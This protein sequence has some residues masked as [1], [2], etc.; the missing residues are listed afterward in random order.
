MN[1]HSIK[2]YKNLHEK[3]DD[4]M[5]IIKCKCEKYICIHKKLEKINNDDFIV[6]NEN[7]YNLIT[8]YSYTIKQLKQI[9]QI[10][11]LKISGIRKELVNR[12]FIYLRL[13]FFIIKI[14]KIFR[15]F[16][17]RRY[18]FYHGPAFWDRSLCTN[19][20]DFFTMDEITT[21]PHSQFFSYK[22]LDGFIYGFDILSLYNLILKSS[23]KVQNPY[24]RNEIQITVF[25]HI[26]NIIRISKIYN[27]NIEINITDDQTSL[28]LQKIVELRSLELFQNIDYLGNYSNSNWFLSLNRIELLKFMRELNDIWNFRIQLTSE[29]KRSICPPHGDPFRNFRISCITSE[30][31]LFIVK[32]HILEV[33]EKFVNTGIDRDSKSLGCYYVLGALTLVNPNAA[34]SMPWLYQSFSY[35]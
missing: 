19:N 21:L 2:K 29:I 23:K 4:Y 22:D 3:I 9:A 14:Q 12:I 8:K 13:S 31:D 25:N 5:D 1:I 32:K 27:I 11:K 26:S 15:G 16:L 33:L 20:T 34:L 6:P 7:N 24:N 10:Y 18:N 28:S 30:N 35:F 17:Q